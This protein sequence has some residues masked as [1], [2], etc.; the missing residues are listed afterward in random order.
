MVPENKNV[1]AH[2]GLHQQQEQQQSLSSES[3]VAHDMSVTV[4]LH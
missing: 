3:A 4:S 1:E 2:S